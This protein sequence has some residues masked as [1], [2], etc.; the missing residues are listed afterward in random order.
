MSVSMCV[1]VTGCRDAFWRPVYSEPAVQRFRTCPMRRRLQ[2]RN[3]LT[4]ESDGIHPFRLPNERLE[5]N[6][7]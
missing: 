6:I 2:R 3:R 1:Y 4:A 5:L 7:I